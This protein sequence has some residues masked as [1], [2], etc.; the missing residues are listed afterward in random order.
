MG[1]PYTPPERL[2]FL[3]RILPAFSSALMIAVAAIAAPEFFAISF[4]LFGI[5][6]ALFLGFEMQWRYLASRHE[7]YNHAQDAEPES[8]QDPEIEEMLKQLDDND[9]RCYLRSDTPRP[10]PPP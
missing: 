2:P 5:C 9:C 1:R 7:T 4:V 8:Q 10:T 3:V 6:V